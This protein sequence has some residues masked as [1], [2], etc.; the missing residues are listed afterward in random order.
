MATIRLQPS[1]VTLTNSAVSALQQQLQVE[2]ST[3]LYD[4]L[5]KLGAW[6]S[7]LVEVRRFYCSR[8]CDDSCWS[9]TRGLI[10]GRLGLEVPWEKENDRGRG[11]CVVGGR[12]GKTRECVQGKQVNAKLA[13]LRACSSMGVCLHMRNRVRDDQR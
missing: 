8:A 9:Q 10:R 12:Q 7:Q 13:F 11:E 2:G 5:H 3:N 4:L 1:G 6:E